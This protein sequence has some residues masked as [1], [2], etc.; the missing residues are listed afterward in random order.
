M[1]RP[2]TVSVVIPTAGRPD[3]LARAVDS[4]LAQTRPPVEV[5]VVLDGPDEASHE[6]LGGYVAEPVVVIQLPVRS[7]D[8]GATARN[9]GVAA[10][11]GG[12]I[13]FLDD[14]DEWLA[15]KLERQVAAAS[16]HPAAT[17][18][19]CR[20]RVTDSQSS[21]VWPLRGPGA[22]EPIGEYL[23]VRTLP[24]EGWLPTTALMAPRDL[25]R[26]VPFREGLRQHVDFD[27]A[28]RLAA[29][30]A[31][32]VVVPDVLAVMHVPQG[33]HSVSTHSTWRASLAWAQES[34]HLL[35]DRAFSA[36]V[37]TEAARKSRGPRDL[38]AS[39]V[40]LRAAFTGRPRLLD[41]LRFVVTAVLPPSQRRWVLR[42]GAPL[43][44]RSTGRTWTS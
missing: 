17:V 36:F 1:T 16:A 18:V 42:A 38:R 33:R 41:L 14:D 25:C 35:G 30:G 34:R 43:A 27:W 5:I 29:G 39:T 32:F 20:V 40:M 8:G 44:R 2:P 4:A 13:A 31:R 28:L 12:W 37:L 10:A 21:S 19:G 6:L 23:F 24:G 26:E 9:R 15:G 3:T 22:H 7:G 11:N